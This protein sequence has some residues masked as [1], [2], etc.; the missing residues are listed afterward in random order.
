MDK[1]YFNWNELKIAGE[2]QFESILILAYCIKIGYNNIIA[3]SSN[4][5]FKLLNINKIP[6]RLFVKKYLVTNK[7]KIISHFKCQEP[8][9]YFNNSYFLTARCL[10]AQKIKYLFM[11]GHRSINE[12]NS[13]IPVDYID[14]KH[15][16]NLFIKIRNKKLYFIPELQIN[17]RKR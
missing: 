4:H 14:E 5:L 10:P 8:Q 7:G 15:H 12:L 9:S 3:N 2:G 11:L 1:H 17:R 16:N 6:Q 13:F